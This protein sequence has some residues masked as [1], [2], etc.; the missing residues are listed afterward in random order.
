[1][2]GDGGVL[3]EVA[4]A[5]VSELASSAIQTHV[6]VARQGEGKA[7]GPVFYSLALLEYPTSVFRLV[8]ELLRRS[9]LWDDEPGDGAVARWALLGIRDWTLIPGPPSAWQHWWRTSRAF[10]E[11]DFFA[12]RGLVFSRGELTTEP[13]RCGFRLVRELY[14]AFGFVD[15]DMPP[16]FDQ[17][18]GRLVLPE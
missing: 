14:H 13:D 1:V 11:R 10:E 16:E 7:S 4:L 17:R 3:F 9:E 18:S 15:R 6:D 2:F 5:R 12:D 8:A